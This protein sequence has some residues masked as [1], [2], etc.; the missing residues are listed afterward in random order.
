MI[1][2]VFEEGVEA[3]E[4]FPSAGD[5]GDIVELFAL[6]AETFVEGGDVAAVLGGG[7]GGHVEGFADNG[8]AAVDASFSGPGATLPRKVSVATLGDPLDPL[9]GTAVDSD[10]RTSPRKL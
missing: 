8:A 10:D 6:F 1:F 2:E 4:E 7:L 9:R 5:E 3:D